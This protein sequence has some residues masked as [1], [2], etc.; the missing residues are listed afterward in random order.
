MSQPSVCPLQNSELCSSD[1]K[2]EPKVKSKSKPRKSKVNDK[3]K[4]GFN[5]LSQRKLQQMKRKCEKLEKDLEKMKEDVFF[6]N[7]MI[8]KSINV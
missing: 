5:N 3:S 2:Q 7:G 6:L 1:S 4:K 8:I